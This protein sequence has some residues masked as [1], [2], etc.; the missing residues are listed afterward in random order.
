[1][2]ESDEP[3]HLV[4]R[5]ET[6]DRFLIYTDDRGLRVDLRYEGDALW[7]TQAQMARLFGRDV[8]VISRHIAN[9]L[10]EGELGRVDKVSD[11]Q[12]D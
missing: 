5:E 10:E 4:E 12:S 2:A 11:P 3:V 6:G 1:M 9:V 7:M 8:S